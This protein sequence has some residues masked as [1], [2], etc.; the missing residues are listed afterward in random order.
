MTAPEPP[1]PVH[2]GFGGSVCVWHPERETALRCTRCDRP[3]CPECLTPA[4][5]GFH[6]RQCL[7]ESRAAY[8][9][10]RTHAGSDVN[11]KPIVSYLLMAVNVLVFVIV[12]VQARSVTVMDPSPV[13]LNGV[14]FPGE[15]AGGEF[16]R[17]ISSGF[18]HF[19]I[20]HL[21]MNMLSL[22][23]LGPNLER[24]LGRVRFSVVYLLSL[25]GGS[26]AVMLLSEPLTMSAGASGAIFGLMGAMVAVVKR[27]RADPRQLLGVVMI[28]L[29]I[30]F[31][32][33]GISWQAHLGGLVVGGIV[34]AAMVFAPQK[35]RT[36]WQVGVSAGTL[37]VLVAVI[38]YATTQVAPYECFLLAP[39]IHCFLHS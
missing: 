1:P 20:V 34:G 23:M 4:S 39:E 16:Y 25:L 33:Q 26:A 29:I 15:V 36:A 14:L 27:Y 22:Y 24:V 32:V 37:L 2:P 28:N 12:A 19:G 13:M 7:G 18:L 11:E 10:A 8:R 21:A 35:T 30:S 5:V 31:S 6:C 9:P 38:V 17:L 3:A